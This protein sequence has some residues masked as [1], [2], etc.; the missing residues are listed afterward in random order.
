MLSPDKM[1]LVVEGLKDEKKEQWYQY[2][3][4]DM[5]PHIVVVLREAGAHLIPGVADAASNG[6]RIGDIIRAIHQSMPI[7]LHERL[8]SMWLGLDVL[9]RRSVDPSVS[10]QTEHGQ[11]RQD[12]ETNPSTDVT[13][14]LTVIVASDDLCG[15][16]DIQQAIVPYRVG[17]GGVLAFDEADYGDQGEVDVGGDIADALHE[18]FKRESLT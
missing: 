8:E 3:Q 10:A 2:G 5:E 6:L 9:V 12:W 16:C 11:L 17:D 4:R 18:L 14:A 13:E 7:P 1:T 15:G